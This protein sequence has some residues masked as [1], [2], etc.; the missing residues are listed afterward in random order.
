MRPLSAQELLRA[1]ELGLS[2]GPVERAL[3]LLA[4]ACPETSRDALEMLTIG[5][6]DSNLLTLREWTFGPQVASVVVCPGCGQKPELNF[7]VSDL[8]VDS[9]PDAMATPITEFAMTVSEYELLF[10]QL[11]SLDLEAVS[12]AP[13]VVSQRELLFGRCLIAARRNG[14]QT[15]ANDLP[16]EVIDAVSDRLAQ[17]DP[18]ADVQLEI[19][20]PFCGKR[21]QAAFDIVTFFW[22]EIEGWAYRILREVDTL[23]SVYGWSEQDILALSPNRRQLYLEMARA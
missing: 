12:G 7:N 2:Q 8:R 15:A 4:A 22:K 11:N 6:R 10:R 3:T 14:E 13:G 20:C 21:W 16:I 19:S 17:M 9:A 18:Q 1:W 23:A 5:R